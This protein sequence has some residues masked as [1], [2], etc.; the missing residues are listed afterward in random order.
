M[1]AEPTTQNRARKRSLRDLLYVLFG[2][3]GKVTVF[4][5]LLFGMAALM[6]FLRPGLYR[7]EARLLVRL[8]RETVSL[9]P[10]ATIGEIAQ[11]NQSRD[12]EINS[13]LEIL[14]SREIAERVVDELGADVFE[15]EP[16]APADGNAVAAVSPNAGILPALRNAARAVKTGPARLAVSL[17]LSEPLEPREKAV[18][19]IMENVD[20]KSLA[21]TSVISLSYEA[22]RRGLAREILDRFIQAYLEK[23]L[24]VY[25]V[26]DSRQFFE[27]QVSELRAQLMQAETELRDIKDATGISSLEEQRTVMVNTIGTLERS[28]G[29]TE[30]ELAGANAKIAG[31]QEILARIPETVVVEQATGFADYGADLMRSRLYDLRIAEK[32]M[33]ARYTPDS[34]MLDKIREQVNEGVALL[35]KEQSKPMRTEVKKGLSTAYVQMQTA[36][37]S[38]QANTS[39]LESRLEKMRAQIA[40]AQDDLR[41][42]NDTEIKTSRLTREITLLRDS[43]SRYFQKLEQARIDQALK[44]ERISSISVLEAATLPVAPVGPS[45]MIRLALG[46]L[47]ALAGGIGFAFLC[48]YLDHSVKTP[49]DV[50]EKLQLPALASIPRTRPN[51]VCPASRWGRWTRL[52][53]ARRQNVPV[54]WDLPPNVRRHYAA[55]RE[56]LLF[57]ANGAMQD[58]YVVGVT[59]CCRSEGVSTAAANL[60]ATLAEQGNGP[61]LL[62]DANQRHPSIHRIFRTRQAPGLAEVLSCDHEGNGDDLIV[63]RA[64]NLSFVTAGSAMDRPPEAA[65]PARFSRFL[66]ATR[67][68]YRFTVID[69]PALEEEGAPV[70]LAGTCDG[71]ILVVEAE[72]LRWEVITQARQH[73]QQWNVNVLGVLLNKRRFPVP[74]WLYAAL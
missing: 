41:R 62:V 33:A 34:R 25:Y 4:T 48:D 24:A 61:I 40:A 55:F 50:Q 30:A 28:V 1:E 19:R 23:H 17:G 68:E 21:N 54:R 44:S 57:R 7:S 5:L 36:V 74:D 58:H 38:E 6:T 63:H 26:A 22:P 37:L 65:V 32:E 72:R 47:L 15:R 51:T 11:I 3:K 73:L 31:I 59:S 53:A 46:L 2:H 42:L 69:I 71:V 66:H 10:T 35:E 12:W 56:Q 14:K 16:E 70:Q 20:V 27:R 9:D 52:G 67:Q 60:A 13:E 43:Y 49:E 29:E 18:R 45:R 64:A 39:A 8:G